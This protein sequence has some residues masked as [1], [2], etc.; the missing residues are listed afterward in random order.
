MYCEYIPPVI[1]IKIGFWAIYVIDK[2]MKIVCFMKAHFN[3]L[4][5]F[6]LNTLENLTIVSTIRWPRL[7]IDHPSQRPRVPP[8]PDNRSTG[9]IM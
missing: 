2:T 9:L 5:F 3:L 7:K 8:N 1:G 4:Y 6:P